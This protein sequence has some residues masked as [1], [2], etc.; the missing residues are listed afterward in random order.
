MVPTL[1]CSP[2][3]Q[4]Q[5]TKT[6]ERPSED[7]ATSGGHNNQKIK[8]LGERVTALEAWK[9]RFVFSEFRRDSFGYAELSS[10][11][12]PENEHFLQAAMNGNKDSPM[13][14]WNPILLLM[15]GAALGAIVAK[16]LWENHK[17]ETLPNFLS[18]TEVTLFID[19]METAMRIHST[20]TFCFFLRDWLKRFTKG[21]S[22]SGR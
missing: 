6:L 21:E 17:M 2:A 15:T 5:E 20:H 11:S 22:W 14:L 18:F 1:A 4:Q 9:T 19:F 10:F 3:L 12:R 16:K 7:V 13:P 8:E